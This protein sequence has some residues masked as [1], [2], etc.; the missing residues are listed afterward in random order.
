MRGQGFDQ[1]VAALQS[2]GLT[3]SGFNSVVDRSCNFID[4]VMSQSPA[5]G[6]VV[7]T[8]SGVFVTFGEHPTDT[9]CP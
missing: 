9:E 7:A 5:A 8:G 2:V 6:T 3:M 4:L 1:A